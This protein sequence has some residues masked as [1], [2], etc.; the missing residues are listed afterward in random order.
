MDNYQW[1]INETV[2]LL[3]CTVIVLLCV[4]NS[5][6]SFFLKV[7]LNA[8]WWLDVIQRSIRC[9]YD[10]DLVSRVKNELTCSYKQQAQ[11]FSMADK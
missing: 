2:L 9:S 10:D 6:I 5:R 8:P 7:K 3:G 4:L 11:K 1:Y